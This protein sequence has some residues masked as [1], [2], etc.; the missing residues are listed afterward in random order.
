[1]ADCLETIEEIGEEYKEVFME[2]GG[3]EWQ[4]VES[5]NV[6]PTWVKAVVEMIHERLPEVLMA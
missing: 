3:E 5:L 4:L 6:S 1:V 2:H